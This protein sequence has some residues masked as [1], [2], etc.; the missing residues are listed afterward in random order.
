MVSSTAQSFISILVL[1]AMSTAVV[2]ARAQVKATGDDSVGKD[3]DT[4]TPSMNFNTDSNPKSTDHRPALKFKDD[5]TQPVKKEEDYSN[6]VK[7][8]E[9][10]RAYVGYPKNQVGV[11]VEPT[12]LAFD[13]KFN[14]QSFNYRSNTLKYGVDYNFVVTP[15]FTVGVSYTHYGVSVSSAT[16]DPFVINNSS[17]TFDDYYLKG[18]Y[19]FISDSNFNRRLCPGIDIGNDSYPVLQFVNDGVHLEMGNVQDLVVGVNL[20]GQIPFTDKFVFKGIVGYNIG[21]G[22]GN[23]GPLTSKSNDSY[24]LN[25]STDWTVSSTEHHA[26]DAIFGVGFKHRDASLTGQVG[27][28]SDTWQTDADE[29]SLYLAYMFTW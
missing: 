27:A 10:Y 2:S 15:Q 22:I 18:R 24:Y 14:G 1:F 5:T 26:H 13:W 19:C 28:N 11:H 16:A 8:E 21:T 3:V 12:S 17:D 4:S 25:V 20:T 6:G 29:L 9:P 23:S 7:E